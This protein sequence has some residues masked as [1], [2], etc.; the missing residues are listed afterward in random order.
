[1]NFVVSYQKENVSYTGDKPYPNI[2]FVTYEISY[3]GQGCKQGN[4]EPCL[5]TG[6]SQETEKVKNLSI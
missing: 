2:L 5:V 3:R 6:R 4:E 1:M